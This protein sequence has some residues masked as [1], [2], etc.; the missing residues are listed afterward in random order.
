MTSWYQP[1]DDAEKD[2]LEK[3]FENIAMQG[4]EDHKLLFAFLPVV[5]RPRFTT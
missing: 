5:F 2:H 1:Q 3:E 4:D